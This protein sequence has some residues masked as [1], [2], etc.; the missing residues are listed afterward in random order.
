MK[1]NMRYV[2]L[3]LSTFAVA[4]CNTAY[5]LPD[6]ATQIARV[7]FSAPEATLGNSASIYAMTDEDSCYNAQKLR[8]LGGWQMGGM[9]ASEVDLGMPKT[10]GG[11]AKNTYV[12]IPVVA[13]QRF[14]FTVQGDGGGTCRLTMS[15]L[16]KAGHQYEV[17]YYE[18]G[19][20]CS[21]KIDHML[22][23][24]KNVRLEPEPSAQQNKKTCNGFWN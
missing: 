13:E 24:G 18:H 7:R 15:F 4:G 14:N 22:V 17:T 20:L 10:R 23:Q 9:P 6:N 11:Y 21:V 3:A 8:H 1:K 5:R 12:E 2:L 19:G 16:P